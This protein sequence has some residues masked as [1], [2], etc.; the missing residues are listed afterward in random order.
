MLTNAEI[1]VKNNSGI[2]SHTW[3]ISF[4][5]FSS[6][7]SSSSIRAARSS[8]LRFDSVTIFSFSIRVSRRSLAWRNLGMSAYDKYKVKSLF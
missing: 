6:S 1:Y 2:L 8:A 4:C 3:S 7:S 5:R